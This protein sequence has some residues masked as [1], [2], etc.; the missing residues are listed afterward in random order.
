MKISSFDVFDTVLTRIIGDPNSVF[1]LLGKKLVTQS[2]V[3]CS[4]EA[5]A[6]AR[7]KADS[8]AFKNI[9]EKYAL[10]H[11][12]IELAT[13]LG[14][15]DDPREKILRLELELESKLMRPIPVA[16][17]YLQAARE[18]GD[19][20]VFVSD[21][22][23]PSEFIQEQLVRHQFW[24]QG[25]R[26]YVSNEYG[27]S[28][29]TGGLY[30]EL[31]DCEGVLPQD[32]T[33]TGNNLIVDIEGAKK[34]RLRARYFAAGNLNRYE[35]ILESYAFTTEGLSSIMAGASRLARLEVPASDLYQQALRNVT[36]GVVAPI[37]VGYVIWV[38][39]KSQQMGLKRLYF[40]SRD[41]QILLEIAQR[42]L[43]KLKVDCELRYVYG[44][45]L[46]WNL[47][48]LSS[49]DRERAFEMLKRSSWVLD[50]TSAI[51]IRE[52]LARV[53]ITPEEISDCLTAL[54]FPPSDWQKV[55]SHSEQQ[56][57]HPLLDNGEVK[58]LIL[59]KAAQQEAVLLKYLA[60]EK[61]LDATP[62]G[63]V[64]LGWFGSSYDSLNSLLKAKDATIDVGFFYGLMSHPN[65]DRAN[66]KKGYFFDQ[67]ISTGFGSILP[68]WG[69]AP[70]EVFC[71]GDHG[72]VV[73][74]IE[75]CGQVRPVFREERNQKVIDW[76]LPLL[77]E[78]VRRFTE[79]LLIDPSL[80]NPDA[81]VREA[82]EGLLQ[83]FWLNPSQEEAKAWGDY[84]WEY[85]HNETTDFLAKPYTWM[86][87]AWSFF[88]TRLSDH[89]GMWVE[90]S[91]ARSSTPIRQAMQ[92]FLFYERL[93]LAIKSKFSK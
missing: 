84:P 17:S 14:L 30:Q 47:P 9:G 70:L 48:A 32:I 63:L 62:K 44:S 55:L 77:T 49:F 52:F 16:S 7:I 80:V 35:E 23:F 21:M 59:E 41:G 83:S 88:K 12:Y 37:L 42:L 53:S 5:F 1:L 50:A 20:I 2:L 68:G 73:S 10:H 87:V 57:F 33:H 72:T 36:A 58:E 85:G 45:R 46:A 34:A 22:Y 40:V 24:H 38:L 25:D 31:I 93:C 3:A 54:G 92:V 67:R 29:T 82:C 18:R 90:G 65:N 15:N 56:K 27:K 69:V 66:F 74:F 79:N 91:I 75:E 11:I 64:D 78:T 86:N 13:A 61:L 26:L 8:R 51:C 89:Q 43:P 39:L 28:K 81:D 76:G 6:H 4:S 71:N 60:Q 19:R